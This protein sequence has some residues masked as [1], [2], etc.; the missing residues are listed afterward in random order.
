[1]VLTFLAITG[2]KTGYLFPT[3]SEINEDS[4]TKAYEY[5]NSMLSDMHYL[6]QVVLQKDLTSTEGVKLIPGTHTLRKTGFLLAYWGKKTELMDLSQ[7]PTEDEACIL[8]DAHRGQSD[9][10]PP[11]PPS[12][13]STTPLI[14]S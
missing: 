6:C 4:P 3:V 1:M 13:L 12:P 8:L 7:R 11:N 2:R 10:R 5:D 14:H 9:Q